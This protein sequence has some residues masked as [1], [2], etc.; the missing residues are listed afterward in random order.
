MCVAVSAILR[1]L[2]SQHSWDC[3][4]ALNETARQTPLQFVEQQ[5][6]QSLQQFWFR[7][8]I[9]KFVRELY[10]VIFR[11]SPKF[12]FYSDK[13]LKFLIYSRTAKFDNNLCALA[14]VPKVYSLSITRLFAILQSAAKQN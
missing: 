3:F 10:V 1:N 2:F 13:C 6:C 4:I 5:P 11:A 7:Y 9:Y 12:E 14:V 8:K